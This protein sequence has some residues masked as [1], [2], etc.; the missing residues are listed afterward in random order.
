VLGPLIMLVLFLAART[1]KEGT[2][3]RKCLGFAKSVEGPLPPAME[4][5]TSKQ[6]KA[7]TKNPGSIDGVLGRH[8]S[9]KNVAKMTA[10]CMHNA[11]LDDGANLA[12]MPSGQLLS[13]RHN[14]P[15][16]KLS[17][18][19]SCATGGTMAHTMLQSIV[20]VCRQHAPRCRQIGQFDAP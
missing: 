15:T 14:V 10:G 18:A 12:L 4:T 20:L 1:K 17:R 13:M 11:R 9:C 19:T 2:Q 8:T 6:I 7:K 5:N 16:R 3:I